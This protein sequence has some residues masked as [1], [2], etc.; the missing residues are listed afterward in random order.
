M[1]SAPS[2]RASVSSVFVRPDP[3]REAYFAYTLSV[4]SPEPEPPVGEEPQAASASDAAVRTTVEAST[5]RLDMGTPEWWDGSAA[6]YAG[7]ASRA[8]RGRPGSGRRD[9]FVDPAADGHRC[10]AA[11]AVAEPGPPRPG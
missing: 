6:A 2:L 11:G 7:A 9:G 10:R 8:A 1:S 5:P 4:F 3:V